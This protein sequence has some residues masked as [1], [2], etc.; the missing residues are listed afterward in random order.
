MRGILQ[1]GRHPGRGRHLSHPR[2]GRAR[3]AHVFKVA[4]CAHTD[5]ARMRMCERAG[6]LIICA[7]PPA[8]VIYRMRYLRTHGGLDQ[9]EA[10]AR[11]GFL[12]YGACSAPCLPPHAPRPC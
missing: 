11:F 4:V 9:P 8:F 12:Y 6:L 3:A 10:I 2:E 5:D 7:G 1:W